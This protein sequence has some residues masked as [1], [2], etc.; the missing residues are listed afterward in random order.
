MHAM[1]LWKNL[2][3]RDE[4]EDLGIC[5]NTILKQILQG[6]DMDGGLDSAVS[7]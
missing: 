7:R 2:R 5:G 4:I 6:Y 1:F 3:E